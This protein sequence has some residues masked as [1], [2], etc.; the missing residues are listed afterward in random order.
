M[1]YVF[2]IYGLAFFVLGLSVALYPKKNSAFWFAGLLNYVAAFG[3]LHGM[4]EWVDMFILIHGTADWLPVQIIRTALMS[5]S[6]ICLLVFAVKGIVKAKKRYRALLV[7]PPLLLVAW[8][9]IFS[10]GGGE[11]FLLADIWGRYLL[12]A[13]GVFLAFYTLRLEEDEFQRAGLHVPLVNLRIAAAGFFIYGI[14]AGLIVPR[15]GFFPASIINY[16]AFMSLTGLPVQVFRALCALV[17]AYGMFRTLQVFD[18]ESK[19]AIIEA[20][21]NL[22]I[23]VEARTEE[24]VQ[25]NRELESEMAERSRAERFIKDILETVDEAFVVID[26]EYRIITAN[27]AYS[28]Q[29]KWPF[30][31]IIGS[32]C[33]E[34]SHRSPIPC[35]NVGEDCAV[36]HAFETGKPYTSVHVHRDK[37]GG[38]VFVE[39]KAFP[40]KD[41]SGRVIQVIET[42]NDLTEKRKLEDQLRQSQKMHAVGTLSGGIAHDFNNILTTIIGYGEFLQDDIPEGNPDRRYVDMIIA[43]AQRAADLTQSLLA[44]SRKQ[45]THPRVVSV[46][47]I[48]RDLEGMLSRVIRE[49]VE[50]HIEPGGEDLYVKVDRGQMDQVI[51]N[52][53]SN[54]RDAMPQGGSITLRSR[55]V[56]LD[57]EFIK[58]HGYGRP[59][60]YC[61]IS[62][63][64]TGTGMDEYTR[65]QVFEPFFTTKD[66]GKGTGLGLSVVYGIIRQHG[67]YIN[68]QSELGKGTEVNI[69][70]PVSD[71]LPEKVEND[72]AREPVAGGTEKI[73]V[74]EDS[75]NIRSLLEAVLVKAGYRIILAEDGEEAMRLF[76]ENADEVDLLLLDVIM[77]KQDG[78]SVYDA[79]RR[80]RGDVKAVFMSGYSE[81]IIHDKGL[82]KEELDFLQKP[83]SPSELLR[84][85]RQ[86]LDS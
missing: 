62:V 82:L 24:L 30:D 51:M 46:A 66:V 56:E 84:K 45:I 42:I 50:L 14:L 18:W 71:D 83:V 31:E 9:V 34:V 28:E 47:D 23:S 17:I 68:I 13:P 16:D 32:H 64:D 49:D 3:L 69:Y 61:H 7:L 11:R 73:L 19:N 74:A 72:K 53:A 80:L 26:P 67:G 78:R 55:A 12:G 48:F 35:F 44:F 70:V 52:L 2:F 85:V 29:T 75:E 86:V 38:N 60:R 63:T 33:H 6:F 1:L 8:F 41:P 57:D 22:E 37:E 54:A 79:A 43:A 20:R 81:D 76:R 59:G 25:I 15:A 10:N 36:K 21:D 4:N 40:M 39:T 77:P 65:N 58:A 27:R 5:S